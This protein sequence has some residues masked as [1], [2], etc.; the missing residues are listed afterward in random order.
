LGNSIIKAL[1]DMNDE[2]IGIELDSGRLERR[3]KILRGAYLIHG[4]ILL[5]LGS[6]FSIS[7]FPEFYKFLLY[8]LNNF[9]YMGSEDTMFFFFILSILLLSTG[10]LF[11][12]TYYGLKSVK[13]YA[14]FTGIIG[15]CLFIFYWLFA[16]PI[17]FLIY[18]NGMF[19]FDVRNNPAALLV[20][21]FVLPSFVLLLSTIRLWKKIPSNNPITLTKKTKKGIAILFV[22]IIVIGTLSYVVPQAQKYVVLSPLKYANYQYGWGVNPPEGWQVIKDPII[23][24]FRPP[25]KDNVSKNV[26]LSILGIPL[27][28]PITIDDLVRSRLV[29]I[30]WYVNNSANFSLISQNNRTVNGWNAYEF[31]YIYD[32]SRENHTKMKDKKIFIVGNNHEFVVTFES[33]LFFYDTYE[34]AVEQSINSLK[35]V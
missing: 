8:K 18:Y 33:P 35:I 6:W 25:L 12:L 30:T 15:C 26:I 16:F 23:G 21:L 11:I 19:V 34:S 9:Y 28:K 14:R 31:V 7:F 13:K 32:Y 27:D 5:L 17:Y 10:I 24:E 20:I 22:G 3:L 1:G 29:E 4:I 2:E